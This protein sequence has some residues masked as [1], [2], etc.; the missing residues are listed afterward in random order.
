MNSSLSSGAFP[1]ALK[2][3]IIRP[4]LKKQG[5]ERDILTNYRPV[6]NLPFLGKV[7]EKA[8][9]LQVTNYLSQHLLGDP[10]QSAYKAGHSCETALLKVTSD[11]QLALDDGEGMLM[12]MLDLSA[13]YDLVDHDI[14]LS[15]MKSQLGFFG[16]VLK[17]FNSYLKSHTQLVVIGSAQSNEVPLTTGV[18]QG[19][20]LG[21]LLYLIYVLP[22]KYIFKK[23]NISYHCFADDIQIYNRFSLKQD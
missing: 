7:I 12:A 16:M 4:V 6:S 11:I 10:L 13:A 14:L 20:I 23:H 9:S 18:P 5:L 1:S 22:L 2:C 17:W 21:S 15:G 3:A 19:S 8:V